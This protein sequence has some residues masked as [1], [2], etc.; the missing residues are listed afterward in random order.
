[1]RRILRRHEVVADDWHHLCE[2]DGA[3]TQNARRTGLIVPLA[4]FRNNLSKWRDYQGPLGVRLSPADAV[5]ELAADLPRLSLVAAEFPGPGDGRGFTQGRLLRARYHFRGDLRAV[6]AGVKQD[7]I[8]LMARCGFDSFELAAGQSFEE[9]IR[10]LSRYTVAYA[11]GEPL[12]AI[13]RQRFHSS[14]G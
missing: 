9:A 10:A 14:I 6:G 5:E 12:R 2:M 1:M 7:L 4:E 13:E 11:P 8:F 3:V